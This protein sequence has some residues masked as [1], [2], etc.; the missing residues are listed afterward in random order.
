MIICSNE[1]RVVTSEYKF[2]Q[3]GLTALLERGVARQIVYDPKTLGLRAERSRHKVSFYVVRRMPGGRPVRVR[4]GAFPQMT[5]DAART[6]AATV[7]SDIA[8]GLN[9]A[10]AKRRRRRE[11]TLGDLFSH[12]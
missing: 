11:P 7:L 2:T 1:V 5:V 3:A 9:P 10:A 8:K 4:L 12:W 6:E